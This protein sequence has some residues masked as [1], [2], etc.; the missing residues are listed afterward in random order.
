[1]P[2]R[3]ADTLAELRALGYDVREGYEYASYVESVLPVDPEYLW[4][5]PGDPLRLYRMGYVLGREGNW[6]SVPTFY[7]RT[8]LELGH[9]SR[10]L[11]VCVHRS[12][13][14][15]PKSQKRGDEHEAMLEFFGTRAGEWAGFLP[16][17][18]DDNTD[19]QLI[20]DLKE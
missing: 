14:P 1:M 5:Q 6:V 13:L 15:R 17:A 19:E 16:S 9:V 4:A 8:E 3:R 11:V 7:S 20:L 12:G 2:A 18:E 10:E